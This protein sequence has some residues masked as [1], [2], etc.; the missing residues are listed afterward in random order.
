MKT[1]RIMA[2]LA[3]LSTTAC[4]NPYTGYVDPVAT[5]VAVGVGALAVGAVGYTAGYNA[6]PRHHYY[7]APRPYYVAPRP[8]YHHY[9]PAL[10]PPRIY[11]GPRGYYQAR[12]W[13]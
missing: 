12:P 1:I 6:A 4:V 10:P 2:M 8:Y 9:R 5:G 11:Y 13:R 3:A 7:A